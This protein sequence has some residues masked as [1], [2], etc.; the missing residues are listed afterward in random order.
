MSIRPYKSAGD[1]WQVLATTP[2]KN[3]RIPQGY[4]VW[5][6]AKAGFAPLTAIWADTGKRSVKLLTEASVPAGMVHVR[7]GMWGPDFPGFGQ[8]D[9][10]R[11]DDYLIDRTE[12]TNEEF[13]KFVDAG[14]YQ[15]REFW[16]E[17]FVK[18]GR[19][20]SWE[21][22][23]AVFRDSTGRPSP[24]T[25]EAGTYPKGMEKHPV[26][27]VSW[28]EAAAYAEFAGKSLP[29]IYHWDRASQQHFAMFIVPGSNLRSA[30]TRPVAGPGG[31]SGWGTWDMA[32][33]VKEWCWNEDSEGKRFILG[34]GFGEADYMF[35][36]PDQQAPMRREPNYGF[37]CVKL[38]APSDAARAVKPRIMV[39]DFSKEKPVSDDV[40]RA[41]RGLYAYD[42]KPLNART[43]ATETEDGWTRER[44]SF[45][46]AYG[47]ERV[48]ADLY[49][50]RNAKPPYQA[51]VYF[52]GSGAMTSEKLQS[53]AEWDADFIP[54]NG[55]AL[56]FPA[57]KSTFER[58]DGL[59]SDVPTLTATYR[60]H[61]VMWS[62][63]LG[64]TL[65]YLESRKDV[66]A[67][68]IAFV[69]YSWGAYIAPVLLTVDDRP[70]AAVL[71]SGGFVH[72]RALPEAEPI[73]F[74][75]QMR[76][77]TLMLNGRYD[78]MLPEKTSQVPMYRRL[79]TPE[80]DKKHVVFDSGHNPPHL[81]Y[82]RE[83]LDWLDKH[84]GPV[85]R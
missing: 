25:W 73:N 64:R 75:S 6:I 43:D 60:D 52:P 23:M 85:K 20:L 82:V 79:G 72:E 80:K 39:R 36:G 33:N 8:A 84:L 3:V 50:P 27:G 49:L 44:V 46:A 38:L 9:E 51:V 5:R 63:D 61:M 48:L 10:I 18:D 47:G 1:A 2:V 22:A 30:G 40:F 41:Y 77:P 68:K 4:Y 37:R 15:K 58:R 54:L 24:A 13:R 34:G 14:G 45:D 32:G 42:R 59:K 65:D 69:G 83:T 71:A 57:F 31:L 16:K 76:M 66:E 62:K 55:R 74:V 35:G 17:A 21:A 78:S 11:L 26:A 56:I 81:G 7:G 12:V 67:T 29:S 53:A 19:T 70:K 28:Y